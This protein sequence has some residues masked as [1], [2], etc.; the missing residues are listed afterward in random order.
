M[1]FDPSAQGIDA[2][3]AEARVT[4]AIENEEVVLFMKGDARM[5]QCGYSKRA[6]GLIGTYRPDLK[7][8]DA[9]QN[10]D[11]FR[12]ALQERSG[13]E[14]IPQA[15]V[16]GEF[17]GGSDILAELDER[18]ELAETLNVDP[19]EIDVEGAGEPASDGDDDNAEAPF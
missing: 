17:V 1:T 4:E 9:L 7:T 5:P 12:E 8:V 11:A 16:D 18:G 19:E 3:E 14:T 15:F 6:L 10:L 13:W 2:E